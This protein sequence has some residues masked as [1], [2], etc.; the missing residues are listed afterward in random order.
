MALQ[1]ERGGASFF[2][3]T[4]KAAPLAALNTGRA[5]PSYSALGIVTRMGGNGIA[6]SVAAAIEPGPKGTRS[7]V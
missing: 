1:G 7:K 3:E 4:G 2:L 6:G 5:C